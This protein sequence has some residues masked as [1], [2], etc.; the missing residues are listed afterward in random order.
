MNCCCETWRVFIQTWNSRERA[1]AC[2][3]SFICHVLAIVISATSISCSV[4]EP[5]K[6]RSVT[7]SSTCWMDSSRLKS[8]ESREGRPSARRRDNSNAESWLVESKRLKILIQSS[9][10]SFSK[11]LSKPIQSYKPG[12]FYFWLISEY[13]NKWFELAFGQVFSS[14]VE[15]TTVS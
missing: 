4:A 10:S 9:R 7:W 11:I 2:F 8:S 13:P 6:P 5:S 15:R 12:S 3:G 1:S 14:I